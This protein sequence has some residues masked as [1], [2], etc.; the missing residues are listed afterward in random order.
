MRSTPR[1]DGRPDRRHTV[2]MTPEHRLSNQIRLACGQRNW[3]CFHINV[4]KIQLP[5]GSVFNTGV[6]NGWPDLTIITD[7]A[8]VIFIETKIHPRK[9]T[10]DQI[11]MIKTLRERGFIAEVIYTF[12]EFQ[13][14]PF[15]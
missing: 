1:P 15:W 5:D 13:K 9:P 10:A 11:N 7:D 6:P 4:G 12:A 8:R 2:S 3:L 14:M